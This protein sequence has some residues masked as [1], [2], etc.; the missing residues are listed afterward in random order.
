MGIPVSKEEAKWSQDPFQFL[1]ELIIGITEGSIH[2]ET[3]GADIF[4]I[5]GQGDTPDL[6]FTCVE[7]GPDFTPLPV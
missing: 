3:N 6:L 5:Q 7:A 2:I 4:Y 1:D